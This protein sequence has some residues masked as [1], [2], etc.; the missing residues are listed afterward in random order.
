MI[1]AVGALLL[2]SHF[3]VWGDSMAPAL[4]HGDVVHCIPAR[5]SLARIR[6]GS[7]VVAIS[8][9]RAE[10]IVIKRVAALPGE[11]VQ[12]RDDGFI[13]IAEPSAVPS[14]S[15]WTCAASEYFLIGDNLAQSSDSRRYGPVGAGDIIGCVWL[16]VPAHRWRRKGARQYR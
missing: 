1:H 11:R 14:D 3:V 15:G 2:R 12:I 6:R 4:H 13:A 10:R 16:T 9:G 7:L 8:P 5:L